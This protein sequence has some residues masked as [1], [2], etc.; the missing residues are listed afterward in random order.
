MITARGCGVIRLSRCT[1]HLSGCAGLVKEEFGTQTSLGSWCGKACVKS[2]SNCNN[3]F[4]LTEPGAPLDDATPSFTPNFY[5][6]RSDRSAI[7]P[8]PGGHDEA[9]AVI[10]CT[11]QKRQSRTLPDE[12]AVMP[13][14]VAVPPA[15]RCAAG[16]GI[17]TDA[18]LV[19]YPPL[20]RLRRQRP[21]AG[22]NELHEV[23]S[24]K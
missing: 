13:R 7:T 17:C 4:V 19:V 18:A 24:E 12:F 21:C 14:V 2:S 16:V 22:E 9:E 20:P 6:A 11:S 3:A 1:M 15:R 5:A 23:I 10:R 8:K